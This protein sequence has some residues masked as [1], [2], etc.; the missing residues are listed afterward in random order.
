MGCTSSTGAVEMISREAREL[1]RCQLVLER[2]QDTE[3]RMSVFIY[4]PKLTAKS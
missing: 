1:E 4:R 2:E 3:N